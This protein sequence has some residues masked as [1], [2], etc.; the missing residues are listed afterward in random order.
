MFRLFLSPLLLVMAFSFVLPAH[1]Q[2]GPTEPLTVSIS[3]QN[4]EPYGTVTITLGSTLI[5]LSSSELS[6]SVDGKVISE[7]LRTATARAGA[8]GSKMTIV[9]KAVTA[10]QTYQKTLVVTPAQ[11][12]LITEPVSTTHAFYQGASLVAPESRVRLIALPDLRTSAGARIDKKDLGFTWRLG[13]QILQ[14]QSGLGRNILVATA[15]IR[16]RDAKISVTVTTKDKSVIA[17]ASTYISPADPFVRIYKTSPLGG[18]DFDHALSNLFTLSGPEETFRVVPYFFKGTPNVLWTLNGTE[19]GLDKSITVRTTST[20][21]GTAA[22]GVT[23]T[24]ITASEQAR[25]GLTLQFGDSSDTIF[26]F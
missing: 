4:P 7:G 14:D 24:D 6:I 5:D 20:S 15:P 19:S 10:T 8:P 9:G 21:K 12:A 25:A 13:D 26:G 11:V 16:Y 1:A 23:A 18:V 17:S 3:P 22:L 2:F